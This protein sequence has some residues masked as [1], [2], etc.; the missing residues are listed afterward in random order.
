MALSVPLSRFTSRVG[1]GSAFF[2]RQHSH[3]M[4]IYTSFFVIALICGCAHQAP[5]A[6]DSK[7]DAG[8]G[9][10]L[11]PKATVDGHGDVGQFI[12]QTAI[13]FGKKPPVT[14]ELPLISDQWHYTTYYDSHDIEIRLSPQKYAD[15]KSFLDQLFG[16]PYFKRDGKD[17]CYLY[18]LTKPVNGGSI[19]ISV[20]NVDGHDITDI[21]IHPPL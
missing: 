14:K 6:T 12:M 7:P 2:V 9:G 16:P 21:A 4:K 20:M 19:F 10:I 1:G 5:V 17:S 3:A 13:H 15:L 18:G 11:A 8:R